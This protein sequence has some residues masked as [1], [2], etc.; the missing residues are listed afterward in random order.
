MIMPKMM[1][2]QKEMWS[3]MQK[4]AELEEAA[5]PQQ[6]PPKEM[7]ETME[8]MWDVPD[9]FD[10]YCVI[11]GILAIFVFG[12]YVFSSIRLLQV[13]PAAIKLF[14]L[15]AGISIGFTILKAV[16]ALYAKS[17]MVISMMLSGMVGVV[18]NV[19]L[20]IVVA[21]GDKKAFSS[22]EA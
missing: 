1:E 10:T 3:D 13:K 11:V 19:I 2:M 22:K 17:F 6:I 4:S 20:L 12:F 5:D 8:K 21:T 14:Y 15:A 9:W 16:V 18:L 7:F